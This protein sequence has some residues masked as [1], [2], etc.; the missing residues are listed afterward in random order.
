[1]KRIALA[2]GSTLLAALM[3]LVQPVSATTEVTVSVTDREGDAGMAFIKIIDEN[4][5]YE[6]VPFVTF[7]E[8]SQ[9]GSIMG[10][11]DIIEG[12]LTYECTPNSVKSVT[13]GMTMAAPL[14]PEVTD[15]PNIMKKVQWCWFFYVETP[16]WFNDYSIIIEWDGEE[17][18][19]FLADYTSAGKGGNPDVPLIPI[20]FETDVK[21]ETFVD[22]DDIERM[23]LVV[24]TSD[25]EILKLLLTSKWWFFEIYMI[26]SEQY[27]EMDPGGGIG[28]DATDMAYD[29]TINILPYWPVPEV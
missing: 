3:I 9:P 18:V 15:L 2:A 24:T 1:M 23:N 6:W 20:D 27:E 8:P 5:D 22:E 28:V 12:W 25:R 4:G 13:M 29:P 16:V 19:S 7:P 26:Q 11:L 10:C 14:D 17:F 21:M